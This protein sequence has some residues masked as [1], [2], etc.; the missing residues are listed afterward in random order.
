MVRRELK[1]LKMMVLI[2]DRERSKKTAVFLGSLDIYRQVVALG[3][4]TAP[5]DMQ[6]LLGVGET[7]KAVIVTVVPE[8]R[9]SGIFTALKEKL[10]FGNGGGIAFTVML[11]S[12]V[13]YDTI[14]LFINKFLNNFTEI[15]LEEK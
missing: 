4:G 8:D 2:V 13:N 5:S 7:E 12:I 10:E 15:K 9:I 11:N 3:T 14:E 1:P 6:T